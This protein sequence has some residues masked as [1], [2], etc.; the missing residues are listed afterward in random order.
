MIDQT[1]NRTLATPDSD[2]AG[3]ERSQQLLVAGGLLGALA[4]SSCCLVPLALFAAGVSGA[5][6]GTLT[7][8]APY[9]PCFLTASA[10]CLGGGYWLRHRARR[11]ACAPGDA[12]ARPLPKRIVSVGQIA[13]AALVVSALAVDFLAPLFY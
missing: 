8:L 11:A 10:A 4:A 12:C 13:A 1:E 9:Q 6:I 2:R 7:R 5:W 3:A